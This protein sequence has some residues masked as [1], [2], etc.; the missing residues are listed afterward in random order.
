MNFLRYWLIN[1]LVIVALSYI[2]PGIHLTSLVAALATA[3]VLGLINVFLK[4][5]LIVLTLPIT[6]LTFGLF[7]LMLNALLITLTAWLVPGFAVDSFLS[8]L[9]FSLLLSLIS[10]LVQ[11]NR[12]NQRSRPLAGL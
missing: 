10:W 8:A 2:L 11:N 6:L 5:F 7:A 9:L 1:T 12:L 4:P 3:L